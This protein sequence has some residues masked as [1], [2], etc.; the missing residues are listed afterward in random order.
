VAKIVVYR[1]FN[2]FHK[3]SLRDAAIN[4]AMLPGAPCFLC[5]FYNKVIAKGAAVPHKHGEKVAVHVQDRG[6]FL[7]V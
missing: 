7:H 5:C 2:N 3:V 6:D 1:D 4:L